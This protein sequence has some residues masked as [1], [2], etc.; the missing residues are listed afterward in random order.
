[1]RYFLV[2]RVSYIVAAAST[3]ISNAE[4]TRRYRHSAWRARA[5]IGRFASV[6]CGV[7][8]G[9]AIW[10]LFYLWTGSTKQG[11]VVLE[12]HT[13]AYGQLVKVFANVQ[14]L[15]VFFS[16]FS[17]TFER[18]VIIHKFG[19]PSS[20]I[21]LFTNSADKDHRFENQRTADEL[22]VNFRHLVPCTRAHKVEDLLEMFDRILK[23]RC[24]R[25][26]QTVVLRWL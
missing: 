4:A 13:L 7:C 14:Y 15:S 2:R 26:A 8:R 18:K 25:N 17:V 20:H 10:R 9:C 5:R 6:R 16:N 19:S 12:T 21:T 3:A 1:M 24:V 23:M 22:D 11:G